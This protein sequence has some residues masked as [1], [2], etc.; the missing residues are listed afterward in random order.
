MTDYT[1][2]DEWEQ[3]YRGYE[4]RIN[5]EG[6]I[7]WQV[8]N[9]TDRL[10]LEP[11]PTEL[12]EQFLELKPLGGRVRVT[13]GGSVITRKEDEDLEGSRGQSSLDDYT[14]V[15]V[16]ELDLDGDLVPRKKPEYSIPVRPSNVTSGD[17]W[18]SVYD[19]AR[20]SFSMD[21]RAW[22]HNPTT[23]K[24]HPVV[25]G[26]PD[27]I[28]SALTRLKPEGGSFRVTPWGDVITLVSAPATKTVQ[29]QFGDL[30]PIVR[31]IIKLRRERADLQMLPLYVEQLPMLPLKV[32]SPRSLTDQLTEEE[33]E[34]LEN[35]AASLGSTSQTDKDTHK[36]TRSES[37]TNESNPDSGRTGERDDESAD[38][39]V[40][41]NEDEEVP[42]DDP[43]AWL[44]ESM[45]ETENR[46]NDRTN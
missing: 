42:M 43:V 12:I 17:L 21:G 37:T 15:Y 24:R 33:R 40:D 9:G 7:W 22:W 31:N 26:L 36:A 41:E 38:E 1:P 34:S 5:N 30:P 6:N 35:W 4:L 29:D 3:H 8:Y 39:D 46:I 25:G 32:E 16:G 27:T 14:S 28:E 44:E 13:E 23:K 45:D 19:G 10:H 2:G 18:P 11:K 20:Y